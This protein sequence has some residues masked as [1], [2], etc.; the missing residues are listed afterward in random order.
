MPLFALSFV[1]SFGV[2]FI[3]DSIGRPLLQMHSLLPPRARARA[4]T[5][6]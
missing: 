3:I 1:M 5:A 4:P 2:A 6:T